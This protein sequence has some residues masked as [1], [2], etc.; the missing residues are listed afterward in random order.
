MTCNCAARGVLEGTGGVGGLGGYLA[1]GGGVDAGDCPRWEP[2]KCN[3]VG[4]C[5]RLF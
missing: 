5:G 1:G 2:S 4:V 3:G